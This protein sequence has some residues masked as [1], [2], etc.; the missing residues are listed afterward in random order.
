MS[1]REEEKW[2]GEL[3]Y[4]QKL[5]ALLLVGWGGWAISMEERGQRLIVNR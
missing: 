4:Q 3:I 5:I 1:S 2:W